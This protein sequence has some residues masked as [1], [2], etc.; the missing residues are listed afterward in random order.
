[1]VGHLRMRFEPRRKTG[2]LAQDFW[3]PH[4]NIF[5]VP[6]AME[7]DHRLPVDRATRARRAFPAL[8]GGTRA[9]KIYHLVVEMELRQLVWWWTFDDNRHD[10]RR[11]IRVQLLML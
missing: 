3:E 4:G 9:H 7:E 2:A 1:M 11:S 8:P 10:I 5:A 6:L